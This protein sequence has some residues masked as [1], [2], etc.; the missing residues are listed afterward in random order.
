MIAGE[1]ERAE[2][3]KFRRTLDDG[4]LLALRPKILAALWALVREWNAAGRPGPSRTHSSFPRWAEIVGGIVEFAGYTCPLESA[5]IQRAAHTDGAD[6]RELAKLLDPT[7]IKFDEL[8]ETARNHG[9]FERLIGN[10]GNLKAPDKSAF[11]Q[12]LQ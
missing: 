4:T 5:E 7:P 3:R 11:G 8:V 10:E 12:M 6:M 9:L 2:D 1:Q